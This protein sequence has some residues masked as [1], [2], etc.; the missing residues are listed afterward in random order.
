MNRETIPHT[1][2]TFT[3]PVGVVDGEGSLH[4]QGGMRRATGHD[5][6]WVSKDLRTQENPAYKII[7][8]LSRVITHLGGFSSVTPELLEQL[9]LTDFIYLREFYTQINPSEVEGI[10]LGEF[11][12]TPWSSCTKR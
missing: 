7:F 10:P 8:L 12:A 1:E 6:I 5:E 3:L 11:W 9:F 2:F 4:R